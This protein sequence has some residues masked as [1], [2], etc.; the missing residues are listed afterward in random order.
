L[1][2]FVELGFGFVRS[3][4]QGSLQGLGTGHGVP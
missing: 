2:G 3:R 1:Q 4:H